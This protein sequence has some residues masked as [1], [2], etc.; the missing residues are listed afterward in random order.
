MKAIVLA[1]PAL[2]GVAGAHAQTFPN[3]IIRFVTIG[4][5]GSGTDLV[6]RAAAQAKLHAMV[7][8]TK[9]VRAELDR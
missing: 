1:L 7:L 5:P 4:G 2:V 8:G 9:L 6:A 3:R